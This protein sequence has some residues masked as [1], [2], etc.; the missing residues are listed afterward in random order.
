MTFAVTSVLARGIEY[1]EGLTKN[2]K[3]FLLLGFTAANTDVNM[4]LGNY[5]GTFWTAAGASDI[6]ARALKTIKSIQTI[7]KSFWNVES[8]VM[9]P[10]SKGSATEAVVQ[11]L[12]STATA[13]GSAT[14]T[15]TFTGL[16]ASAVILSIQH[17]SGG[18]ATVGVTGWG[19]VSA[20]TVANVQFTANPGAGAIMRV[21]YLAVDATPNPGQYQ[22]A[23]D[24]TNNHLPNILWNSGTAPTSGLLLLSWDLQDNLQ[25]IMEAA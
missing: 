20:D 12:D 2:F 10:L 3:Q 22:V 23:M 13:G 14:E 6:G 5:S 11:Y 4:D 16:P 24:G 9:V 7:A 21:A 17:V 18:T 19:S 15:L 1:D 25:P 8:E